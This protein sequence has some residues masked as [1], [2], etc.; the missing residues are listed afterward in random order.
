MVL[1]NHLHKLLINSL[2]LESIL[3]ILSVFLTDVLSNSF[4]KGLSDRHYNSESRSLSH[5]SRDL[6]SHSDRVFLHILVEE[7]VV[8]L[9]WSLL[10][11]VIVEF[12]SLCLNHIWLSWRDTVSLRILSF[13]NSVL[14]SC[15][16]VPSRIFMLDQSSCWRLVL[17]LWAR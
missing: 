11:H 15:F 4:D 9:S 14:D 5:L 8:E 12:T 7:L 2:S 16:M 17:S 6:A 13:S 1:L 10:S 3:N